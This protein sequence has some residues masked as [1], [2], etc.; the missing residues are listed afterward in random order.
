MRSGVRA[1][2]IVGF[3]SAAA[4]SAMP[5]QEGTSPRA[6]AGA[7]AAAPNPETGPMRLTDPPS[8]TI[9]RLP[10]DNPFG[11]A[12]EA[13]AA[14]TGKPVFTELAITIPLYAAIR[15]D[16][17]GKVLDSRRPRDPIPSLSADEKKSFDRWTFDP[18][19]KSGQTVETWAS[20][21]LDLAAQIRAPK[22]E[23]FTLTPVTPTMPIPAPLEWGSDEAWYQSVRPGS[24]GEGAVPVEQVD[25]LPTPKK[26]RWDADSYKGPFSCRFWTKVNAAGKIERAIP[27]QVTDPILIGYMRQQMSAWQLRPAR[28]AGQNADS[29][30]ELSLSG[31]IGY[32][33]EIKQ[34]ANLRKTLIS[35]P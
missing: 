26:T 16:R 29:W 25:T 32:T 20:V 28:I 34:I 31:Q 11:A 19:R 9:S 2:L 15:V 23:Q 21:R 3:F 18:A 1:C 6:P 5:A 27:I 10:A 7:S 13:P 22:V 14:F 4:P 12:V 8:L 30:N 33:T 17:A 24:P 35:A